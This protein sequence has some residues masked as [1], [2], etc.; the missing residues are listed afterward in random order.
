MHDERRAAGSGNLADEIPH[1]LV[2]VVLVYAEARLDGDRNTDLRAHCAHACRDARALEHQRGAEATRLD[3]VAGT[4][5]VEIDLVVT[6]CGAEPRRSRELTSVAAAELQRYGMLRCVEPQQPRGVAVQ[7][8]ARRDHLGIQA[9][10]RR[11][12]PQQIPQMT[13]RVSHHR[14]D[15]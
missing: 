9:C 6:R 5:D 13:V 3:A 8:R 11:E 1:E 12:Q 7:Q 14:R 4:A 15:R 2:R 10:M